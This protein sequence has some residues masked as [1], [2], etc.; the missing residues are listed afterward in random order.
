ML[1]KEKEKFLR[2]YNN[3]ITQR[4]KEIELLQIRSDEQLQKKERE[5]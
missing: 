2:E 4:D 5:R 1:V 3:D